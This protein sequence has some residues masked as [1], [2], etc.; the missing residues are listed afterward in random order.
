MA[1]TP[2]FFVT[3]DSIENDRIVITDADASHIVRVLRLREGAPLLVSDMQRN[4][5]TVSITCA[6]PQRVE[7]AILSRRVADTESPYRITL[8]QAFPK[9]DKL[10]LVVQKAVELGV[11]EVVPVLSERCVSRPDAKSMENRLTRLNRIARAAKG[12]GVMEFGSRRAQGTAAAIVGARA[13][14]IGG[15]IGTACTITDELYGVPALGTMAHAWVQMFDTEYDAFKTYCELYPGNAIMLVDTYD[16][17]RS[18]IPNAIRAF[19]EVLRP[20]GIT[21]CGIRLDSGDI[22][23]LSRKAREMLDEAGWETATITVSLARRAHA[24]P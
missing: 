8:Y 6:S 20:K 16:T 15:C 13:A 4:E 2:L 24:A 9:A 23:Y 10:E 11:A 12:R 18:G 17:L 21:K 22:A 5:Y 19:D 3:R 1:S 7:C 14:Y